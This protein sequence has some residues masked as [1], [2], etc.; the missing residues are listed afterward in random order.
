MAHAMPIKTIHGQH[1]HY[2]WNNANAPGDPSRADCQPMRLSSSAW[3]RPRS[4]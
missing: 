2:G 3:R 1:C 4:T